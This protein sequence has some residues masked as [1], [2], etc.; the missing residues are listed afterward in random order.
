[1]FSSKVSI[2]P[3]MDVTDRHFRYLMRILS[4]RVVLYTEMLTTGALLHNCPTRF[5]AYD[6]AEHPLVLQLGGSNP[7]ELSKCAIIAQKAG[8]DAINLNVGCPSSRVQS[9][10]IGACLMAE[11]SLV[12]DCVA[13]MK[14][15]VDMPVSVKCRNGIDELDS[16]E[17]L[18]GFITE[19]VAAGCSHVIIHAR[20]AWLKGLSPKQN[21]DI[22]PLDYQRVYRIQ[23][24][25]PDLTLTMNGGIKT[26]GDITEH[27][28]H[29]SGVM[30]GRE[31]CN[32]PY[33]IAHIDHYI[34]AEGAVIKTRSEVI[35]KYLAYI[36]QQMSQGV[37]L[38]HMTRPLLNLFHGVT[39]GKHWRRTLSDELRNHADPLNLIEHCIPHTL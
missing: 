34:Y 11:P 36:R 26:L 18:H 32:N 5:L 33:L 20:K 24:A 3:M 15:A 37:A 39:G 25:F 29:V 14:E 2:A 35:Q 38:K 28:R 16:Y 27:L 12:A 4:H 8:Y 1:M 19:I 9:G 23:Q 21:R 13:A 22:P 10:A 30:I 6:E 17:H 7:S 31:A